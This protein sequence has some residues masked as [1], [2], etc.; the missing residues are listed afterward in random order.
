M[1]EAS[2]DAL[3]LSGV[4]AVV[5][6]WNP[7]LKAF[8]AALASYA[9]ACQV[10]IVDNGSDPAIVAALGSL[11]SETC[12]LIAANANRGIATAL[13]A[14]IEAGGRWA[15]EYYFLLDQDSVLEAGAL[16][17]LVEASQALTSKGVRTPVVGPL[18][19]AYGDGMA[20]GMYQDI[21]PP[22][23]GAV[24][25]AV[26][27]LYTSGMLVPAAL[28][29]DARQADAFFIDYV[30]TEWC[31]RV[32]ALFGAEMFLVP[33]A[34][35]FHQ[36][37]DSALPLGQLRKRPLLVHRPLRQYFQLRNA[38]WMLRLAYIPWFARIRM[39][40]R[41]LA[42]VIVLSICVAPRGLRARYVACA[43][44]DG[45]RGQSGNRTFLPEEAR[46]QRINVANL[47]R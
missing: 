3:F 12:V 27:S 9:T 33:S 30:D 25:S 28:A 38:L 24:G 37:G 19:V 21:P 22:A 43:I 4:V 20:I 17:R 45:I 39:A 6:T 2:Q 44:I 40:G 34:R 46:L 23:E 15:P 41:C 14:G 42:R 13:N 7:D 26:E 32:R 35:I 8:R 31:Y 29:L 18:P 5:V 11:E 36:V 10:V 1:P 47:L 16:A